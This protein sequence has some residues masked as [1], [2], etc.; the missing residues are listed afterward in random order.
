MVNIKRWCGNSLDCVLMGLLAAELLLLVVARFCWLPKGW[1]VLIA[2]ALVGTALVIAILWFGFSILKRQ[3]FQF[4]IRSLLALAVVIAVLCSWFSMSVR[5]ARRQREVVVAIIKH[6][7]NVRYE[8]D[9]PGSRELGPLW[10]VDLLGEDFFSNAVAV[11]SSNW[12]FSDNDLERLAEFLEKL[13]RLCMLQLCYTQLTDAGLV[14]LEEL[15]DLKCLSLD[16]CRI[17]DVGLSHL[18]GMSE[19]VV[20]SLDDTDITDAGLGHLAGMTSLRVLH[21][22]GTQVTDAGLVHLGSLTNLE[23]LS[24]YDTRVTVKGVKKL[25]KVLPKCKILHGDIE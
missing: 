19:L 6:G 24:L 18:K 5:E 2:I 17:A 13:P 9:L 7:G 11:S 8:W 14:H 25:Q 4:G 23:K 12:S 10:L 21:L 3:R 20:L 15:R 16:S 1:P 22:N